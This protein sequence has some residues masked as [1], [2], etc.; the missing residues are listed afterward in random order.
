MAPPRQYQLHFGDSE[1]SSG[2]SAYID[3]GNYAA[4]ERATFTDP[5]T[6]VHTPAQV[7]NGSGYAY[8]Q[9]DATSYFVNG[10]Q[11]GVTKYFPETFGE[12]D[13]SGNPPPFCDRLRVHRM[14]RVGLTRRVRQRSRESRNTST[15]SISAG[16]SPAT[17][18]RISNWPHSPRLMT[19]M[20]LGP[21]ATYSGN[22]IGD[23][24]YNPDGTG[25]T[26]YTATGKMAMDWNFSRSQGELEISNFDTKLT[27]GTG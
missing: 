2:H 18:P 27:P 5:E 15:T 23:V 7:F 4:I 25:W 22:V 26:T 16:G 6:G 24:A 12:A 9:S 11:L 8:E 3:D 14:G 20:A 19:F 10:D 17:S 21:T 13:E 1:G